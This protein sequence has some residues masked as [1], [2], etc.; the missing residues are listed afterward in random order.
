MN[1]LKMLRQQKKLTQKQ[2]G[3]KSGLSQSY[4]N[5]LENGKKVN[6][7]ITALSRIANALDVSV[8]ELVNDEYQEC[9]CST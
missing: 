9:L 5:E 2:L 8:A 3:R 7:S 6:P 1:K 4:I